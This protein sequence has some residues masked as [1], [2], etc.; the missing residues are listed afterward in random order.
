MIVYLATKTEFKAD[1]LSNW[2]EEKTLASF[3]GV[4]GSSVGE[5]ELAAWRNSLPYMDRVLDDLA[6]LDKQ[7]ASL[8][9]QL[10]ALRSKLEKEID[11][12]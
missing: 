2:I 10:T 1:I 3:K 7:V 5:R 12:T 6:A 4:L 8:K 9:T 11:R